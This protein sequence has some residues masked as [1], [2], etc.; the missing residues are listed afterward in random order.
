MKKEEL[1][2][3]QIQY[4]ARVLRRHTDKDTLT[5]GITAEQGRTIL[6]LHMHKN[7]VVHL[8]DLQQTFKLRKSSITSLINNLEKNGFVTRCVEDLDQRQKR[9]ELTELGEEKVQLILKTFKE[10]EDTVINSLTEDE[11]IELKYLLNKI[12]K[13]IENF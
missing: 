5:Y 2:T 3:Y 10:E 6:Y 7:E 12:M 1:L 13:S 9:I 11:G 4:I 8:T